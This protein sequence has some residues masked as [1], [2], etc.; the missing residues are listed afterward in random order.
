SQSNTKMK[1]KARALRTIATETCRQYYAAYDPYVNRELSIESCWG[2]R[3]GIYRRACDAAFFLPPARMGGLSGCDVRS[4]TLLLVWARE[5]GVYG[6][7]LSPDR[8]P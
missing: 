4:Q 5:R 8:L 3:G 6:N 1:S 2:A 7:S